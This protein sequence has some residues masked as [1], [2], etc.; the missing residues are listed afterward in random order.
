MAESNPQNRDFTTP[1]IC[2]ASDSV[3]LSSKIFSLTVLFGHFEI[4]YN[5]K[6]CTCKQFQIK[7]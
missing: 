5:D 7:S 6:Y 2:I 3:F 1:L 4:R